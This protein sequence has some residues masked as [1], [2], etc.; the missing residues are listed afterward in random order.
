LSRDAARDYPWFA[1]KR[2]QNRVF[3]QEPSTSLLE[4]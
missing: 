3:A 4:I 2:A 1:I